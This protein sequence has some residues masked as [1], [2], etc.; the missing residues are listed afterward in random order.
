MT[1]LSDY[2]MEEHLNRFNIGKYNSSIKQSQPNLMT[3][4]AGNITQ[5]IEGI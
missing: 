1:R 3:Y 2:N 4:H 5:N